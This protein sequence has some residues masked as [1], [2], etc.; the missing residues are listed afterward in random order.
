MQ[1]TVGSFVAD[2]SAPGEKRVVTEV[3]GW[4]A[5]PVRLE[6]EDRM[7]QDGGWD[8]TPFHSSRIVTVNGAV[9]A[10]SHAAAQ[11]I[12]E[13]LRGLSIRDVHEMTVTDDALGPRT[14][15]VRIESGA[16]PEWGGDRFFRY[17]L[18]L[19]AA[20]PLLY[21]VPAFGAAVLS[22]VGGGSGLTFPLSFPL[23]YGVA[24]GTTPGQVQVDNVGTASYF[25]TLGIDG[26][27]DESGGDVG[28]DGRPD[29]LQRHRPGWAGSRHRLCSPEDSPD[30]A[31]TR[32]RVDAAPGVVRRCVAGCPCGRGDCRVVRR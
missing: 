4:G 23:D 9:A 12:A 28:G 21:G 30:P 15:L 16:D 24:P 27:G 31:R 5:P 14:S 17:S 8:S 10:S 13:E 1:V 32:R 26:A 29:R 22:S 2:Y 25:P 19:R 20:D 11:A 18:Q 6:V 3:I 7:Q